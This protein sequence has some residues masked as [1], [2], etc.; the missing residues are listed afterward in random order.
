MNSRRVHM[1]TFPARIEILETAVASLEPQVDEIH[2]VLNEYDEVPKFLSKFSKVNPII[3][4]EDLKDVG[5]FLPVPNPDDF[6][7]LADDDLRY[8]ARYCDWMIRIAYEIG[9][10]DFV[11]G[12]HGSVFRLVDG[13]PVKKRK[14]YYYSKLLRQSVCVDELGTGTVMA[15]GKNIAPLEYMA[16][17][18]KFV[19][20]RYAKWCHEQNLTKVAIA[21]PSKMIRTIRN[22]GTSIY[23]TFTQNSPQIV[24]DEK[25]AYIGK[26]SMVGNRI[27]RRLSVAEM[28]KR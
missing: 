19:D 3:P 5:K 27:D 4:D 6:V 26:S 11:F 21:R 23:N 1:A 2:L 13:L 20:V 17:S 22:S 25:A 14:L 12:L 9:L 18:R 10:D 24:L 8:H 7:F 15:L 28:F 16:T